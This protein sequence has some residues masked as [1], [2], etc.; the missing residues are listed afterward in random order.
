MDFLHRLLTNADGGAIPSRVTVTAHAGSD[1][2]EDNT[3]P[4]I[5]AALRSG[6]EIVEFD[7][8]V[9]T[10][11]ELVLSHN[12]PEG[13]EPTF[14]E[15]LVLV[16]QAKDVF[17]NIDVKTTVNID[18]MQEIIL[19]HGMLDRVFYTGIPEDCVADVK[20]KSPL[21]QYYINCG[22]SAEN[23]GDKA[24]CDAMTDRVTELGGIGVNINFRGVSQVLAD[25]CRAKG[26][27]LS[28]WTVN[29]EED[30]K[31]FLAMGADNI[32]T[33]RPTFLKKLTASV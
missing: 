30:M 26:L 32:T 1:G 21:V 4:S 27:L 19:K 33:E 22:G 5:E 25:S 7:L 6:A 8:N 11:G 12:A 29:E 18:R 23:L 2:T 3:I 17:I 15:A 20:E 13:G 31:K 9:N 28:V 16:K 24:F 10:D 14:E